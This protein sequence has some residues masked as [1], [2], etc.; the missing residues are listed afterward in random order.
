MTPTKQAIYDVPNDR[1]INWAELD[2]RVRRLAN[3]LR[4]SG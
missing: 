1:R 2:G 4:G 3:G